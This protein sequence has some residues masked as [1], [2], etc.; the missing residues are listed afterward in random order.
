MIGAG[1]YICDALDR[2]IGSRVARA[3]IAR[4]G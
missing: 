3:L 4:A 1:R 2:P